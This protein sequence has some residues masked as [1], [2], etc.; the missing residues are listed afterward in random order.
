[1]SSVRTYYLEEDAPYRQIT[2]LLER[3]YRFRRLSNRSA[4]E[5]VFLHEETAQRI[6]RT[7]S[8]RKAFRPGARVLY[9]PGMLYMEDKCRLAHLLQ[10]V[11][12]HPVTYVDRVPVGVV[13]ADGR[14]VE[15]R[16]LGANGTEV[17][18][19]QAPPRPGTWDKRGYVLQK[20]EEDIML[21]EG[22]KFDLRVHAILLA[23][24]RYAIH[25]D[26]LVRRCSAPY[27]WDPS[28][29]DPASQITNM[30]IQKQF[31]PSLKSVTATFGQ[32]PTHMRAQLQPAI[33]AVVADTLERFVRLARSSEDAL[34]LREVDTPD[35]FAFRMFGFDL[36]PMHDGRIK[37]LEV[38]YRPAI[39]TVSAVAPFYRAL[40]D[41]MHSVLMRTE[42]AELTHPLSRPS[43]DCPVAALYPV[44][45]DGAAWPDP[46]RV[47][48]TTRP[49][50]Q[51]LAALHSFRSPSVQANVL[52][53]AQATVCFASERCGSKVVRRRGM[54]IEYRCDQRV[55]RHPALQLAWLVVNVTRGSLNVFTLPKEGSARDLVS[56]LQRAAQAGELSCICWGVARAH[57]FDAA[58]TLHKGRARRRFTSADIDRSFSWMTTLPAPLLPPSDVI[59]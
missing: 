55:C 57:V 40:V 48:Y 31:D 17:Q 30:S 41:W 2:Q 26:A 46:L 43:R 59:G 14:W 20:Y 8:W 6:V 18:I 36:L 3:K 52:V 33:L 28:C 24:G 34:G 38:N 37:L 58:P 13:L 29:L 56:H 27:A 42:S 54:R 49:R 9:I 51:I 19:L 23:N 7:Q 50:A 1:M 32:L 45:L 39:N 25:R 12:Y 53:D 22:R 47:Q 16:G 35:T 44:R 21:Y 11:E 5:L 15:K 4:A 10:D